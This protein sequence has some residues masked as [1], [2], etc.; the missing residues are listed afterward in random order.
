MIINEHHLM[1]HYCEISRH[2]LPTLRGKFRTLCCVVLECDQY[3][4]KRFRGSA[5]RQRQINSF[6]VFLREKEARPVFVLEQLTW[7]NN[8]R[9]ALAF[10]NLRKE[11]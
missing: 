4:D 3:F 1:C 10:S 9:D 6:Q 5:L 2:C 11:G 7:I 8:T